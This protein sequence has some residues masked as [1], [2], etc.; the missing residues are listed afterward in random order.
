MT[1]NDPIKAILFDKDGT[2]FDFRLTWIPIVRDF[3]DQLAGG[4]PRIADQLLQAAGYNAAL[5]R[6]QADGPLAAGNSADIAA[7]WRTLLRSQSSTADLQ[8]QFDSFSLA[9]GPA[10]S[11]PVCDLK[12]L[13]D[14]LLQ[15]GLLLGLA[16]S[17]CEAATRVALQRFDVVQ[18]FSWICG[19]DSGLGVKPDPVVVHNYAAA[20][21]LQ[22]VQIAVIGDTLHDMHMARGSGAGLAIAVL[23]GAVER[24]ILAPQADLVLDSIADLPAALRLGGA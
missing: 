9:R 18:A 17:D 15:E 23:T 3:V 13:F 22:P 19:Y 24:D 4:N 16:T 20:V 21:G 6:F 1:E 8:R 12:K 10:N 7:V 11:V 5:D 14:N 2:L